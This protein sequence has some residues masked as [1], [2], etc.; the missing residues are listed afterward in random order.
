VPSPAVAVR[1]VKRVRVW[2][3]VTVAPASTGPRSSRTVPLM[4]P[5]GAWAIAGVAHRSSAA[6]TRRRRLPRLT[7]KASP[8]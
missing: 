6:A 2:M 5:A 1:L 8:S 3:T 4:R 7:M